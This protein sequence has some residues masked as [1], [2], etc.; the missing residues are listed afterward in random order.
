MLK[1]DLFMYN[2][3][4]EIKCC[5]EF[6]VQGSAMAVAVDDFITVEFT[7]RQNKT[8]NMTHWNYWLL[9]TNSNC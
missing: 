5:V 1:D 9:T 2:T 7:G 8:D 3:V 4:A 6:V